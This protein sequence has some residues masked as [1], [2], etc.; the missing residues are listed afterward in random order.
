MN[1]LLPMGRKSLMRPPLARRSRRRL[2][3]HL[4][5]LLQ[6]QSLRLGHKEVRKQEAQGASASPDEKDLCLKVALVGVDLF[7]LH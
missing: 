1:A 6:R 5:D 4:I 7:L 3:Q 2:L